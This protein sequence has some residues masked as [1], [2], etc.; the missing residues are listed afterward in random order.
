MTEV[1]LLIIR[2]FPDSV[3]GAILHTYSLILILTL[4]EKQVFVAWLRAIKTV[5]SPI[6]G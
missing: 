2:V 1:S 3:I 5:V 6:L 4:L